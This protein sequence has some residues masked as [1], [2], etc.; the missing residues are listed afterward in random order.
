MTGGPPEGG[1]RGAWGVLRIVTG[2]IL[3]AL[4][5]IGL[6]VPVLQGVALIFAGLAVLASHFPWARRL[7][8]RLQGWFRWLLAWLPGRRQGK[9]PGPGGRRGEEFHVQ[10]G[11]QA[12]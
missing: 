10:G 7:L 9:A 2:S 5:I 8:R 3:L 6:V 12:D 4:G 1:K 11:D